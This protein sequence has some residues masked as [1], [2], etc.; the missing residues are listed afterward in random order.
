MA[1]WL[2]TNRN[3]DK[4]ENGF[5]HKFAD[6]TFWHNDS[7]NLATSSAWVKFKNKD[8]F[9]QALVSITDQY[10]DPSSTP[11]EDQKHVTFFVHGYNETWDRACELYGTVVQNLFSGPTSLGECILFGWP[12]EGLAIGYLPDRAEA[13]QSA[14]DFADVLSEL[15][16]WMLMKQAACA[17]DEK[18]ACKAKTSVIAHSM[19]NYLTENA[20]NFAWTR[21]NRPLLMSLINQLLMIA[22]DVDNDLFRSGDQVSHGDGEGI[23]NL[24]YRVTALYSGRDSVLGASAGLKHF[25]KRRL[26]RS[27]LDRSCP[28]PDNVWDVDCSQLISSNVGGMQVHGAYFHSDDCYRLMRELLRGVD[29][30]VLLTDEGLVPPALA[31]SQSASAAGDSAAAPKNGQP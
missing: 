1:Y 16:D 21:K 11:I 24:T 2:I 15:Y 30:T 10:P 6:L 14:E 31:K 26:G 4:A 12:S 20:M 7:G 25:G 23:A 9:R 8:E 28:I 17:K 27:G 29:R 19:G 18:D 5:G 3:V 22:A 13:R